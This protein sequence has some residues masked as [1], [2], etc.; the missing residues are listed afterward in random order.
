M[1]ESILIVEDDA[2][3]ARLIKLELEHEQYKTTWIADGGEALDNA[4]KNDY[5]LIIL[6]VMLPTI[7]GIEVLRRLK[8]IKKTPVIIL[9]ARDQ[10][11]DKVSG[12]DLG[13][14]DYVTK[15]FDF[16]ELLARIRVALR[17][18]KNINPQLVF[19]RLKVDAVSRVVLIDDNEIALTKKEFDL[20]LYL[21]QH[22]DK[23]LSREK[24]VEAVWGYDYYDNTNL[25]DV[26]IRYL[27][28][29]IEDKYNIK[30]IKTVRGSGYTIREN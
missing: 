23:V 2:G 6:D 16:T 14:E 27:R 4:I 5:D 19:D 1:K 7:N 17:K 20:L 21:L 24:I 9:T 8:T 28:G 29:K 25:V 26:Y 3:I 12:L 13:A 10:V 11:V 22:K 30:L 18:N 15:P